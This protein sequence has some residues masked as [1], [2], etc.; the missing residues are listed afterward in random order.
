MGGGGNACEAAKA[1]RLGA[2][3]DPVVVNI[4]TSF[5]GIA[6]LPL[7]SSPVPFLTIK[8]SDVRYVSRP[9]RLLS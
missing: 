6:S 5:P 7:L 1:S 3:S 9:F 8:L 4:R 2:E